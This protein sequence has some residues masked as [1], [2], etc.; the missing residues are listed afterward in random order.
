MLI[1]GLVEEVRRRRWWWCKLVGEEVGLLGIMRAE[2]QT[3]VVVLKIGVVPGMV[4]V[5]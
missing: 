2:D 4:E 3:V 5:G 1:V